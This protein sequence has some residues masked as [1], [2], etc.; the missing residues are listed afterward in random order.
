VIETPEPAE[1]SAKQV[2]VMRKDLGMR[3]GKMIAQG[4]HASLAVL[5]EGGH[6]SADGAAFTFALDA[7]TTQWLV[8]GRFTKVCVSVDSEAALDAIVARARDAGVPCALIVDSG[9]TEFHG[10]PTK[11]CCA[12]GPAWAEAVDAITGSLSLL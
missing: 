7:A 4:A 5:I 12:V 9:R 10:V 1:R 3:K 8:S 2:I 6:P 11:T